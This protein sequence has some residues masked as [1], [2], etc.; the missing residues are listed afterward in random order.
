MRLPIRLTSIIF[1]CLLVTACSGGSPPP[2][3]APESAPVTASG[4][5]APSAEWDASGAP[6]A[7]TRISAKPNPVDFCSGELQVVEVEWDLAASG[8]RAP[9]IWVQ[10]PNG[11]R[12]IWAALKEPTGSKKTGKWTRSGMRFIAIDGVTREVVNSLT[13]ESQPCA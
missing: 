4:P 1:P 10:E 11:K 5:V 12:Q 6:R 2:L 7:G 9:Q 13:I 8:V 3:P